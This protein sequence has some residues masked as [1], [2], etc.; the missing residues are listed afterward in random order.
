MKPKC[1]TAI[2]SA[3]ICLSHLETN[4]Q[5]NQTL[6]NLTSPTSVNQAL[7]PS[8]NNSLDLGSSSLGWRNIYFGSSLYLNGSPLLLT[9]RT[10]L[11]TYGNFYFGINAGNSNASPEENTAFGQNALYTINNTTS[12]SFNCA[13][14]Y[15]ALYYNTTGGNNTATGHAALQDNT[16]G[17]DNTAIGTG[18]GFGNT[19]GSGNTSIGSSS[20]ASAT[21]NYN[22]TMGYYSYTQYSNLSNCLVLG[23]YAVATASNQVRVGNNLVTSIGG[24]VG[25]TTLSDGRYKKNVKENVEGLKFI[26]SLRPVSYTFDIKSLTAYY[27]KGRNQVLGKENPS[28]Y[29]D[30]EA[31]NASQIVYNGFIAQEVEAAAKKLNFEFSGVDKPKNDNDLYGL[32][33]DN[34]VAPL[35]KAVQELSNMNDQKDSEIDSLQTQINEL[36]SLILSQKSNGNSSVMGAFLEQNVPNPSSNTTTIGYNLPQGI[37]SA[38]LVIIDNSGRILESFNVAGTGRNVKTIDTS[39]FSSGVYNY[40]LVIDGQYAATRRMILMKQ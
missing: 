14:G 6:S 37:G 29:L 11:L 40:S 34:F 8:S 12:A 2:V 31:D 13:I 18:A 21:G 23:Y 16:T 22:T 3:F 5:A 4:A 39:I 33:Y 36:R 25:W 1:Y 38:Q 24:Q 32:R 30:K 10:G 26:N 15:N 17:T 7:L 9:P 20:S 27:K 35:V 28:E 19:T